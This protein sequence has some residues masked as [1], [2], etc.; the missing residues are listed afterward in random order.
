MEAGDGGVAAVRRSHR[1]R[2]TRLEPYVWIAPALIVFGIFSV[3]PLLVGV[4]LS[5]VSWDGIG[6]MRPVGLWNYV[7]VLQDG[8]FWQ[9]MAHNAIYALGTV[10]GK[11]GLGLLL[12][13]L[14]NQSLFGRAVFRTALFLPVVLSM[15]VV[16]LLWSWIYNWDF[17]LAN[18]ILTALGLGALK[19][20]W[21]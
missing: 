1:R 7:D 21:L 19:Q 9:A 17:G 14:L 5:F 16:G 6:A 15:V 10:I 11:L 2:R 8:R 20:D 12:A 3:L 13:V 4:W 18:S